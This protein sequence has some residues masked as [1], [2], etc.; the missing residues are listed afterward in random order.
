[1]KKSLNY[2]MRVAHRDVGFL[3]LGLVIIYSLSGVLLIY[4]RTDVLKTTTMIEKTLKPGLTAEALNEE[5]KLK[6]FKTTEENENT[7]FFAEGK[8][9]KETG[10]AKY[11][12]KEYVFPLQKFVALHKTSQKTSVYLLSTLFGICLFFLAVSSLWMFKPN[13]K[14]FKRGIKFILIGIILSTALLF[15]V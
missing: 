6:N 2:Y 8:Y 14:I 13:T 11:E 5:L 3:T 9:N 10:K 7:I 4:R 15:M 12:T 1:M